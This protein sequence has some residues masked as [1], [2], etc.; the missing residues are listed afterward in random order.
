MTI[1]LYFSNRLEDL[2]EKLSDLMDRENQEKENILEGSLTIVPN[3]N[4]AK[5]L[6]LTLAK[7]RS[8]LMNVDFQYLDTGLWNL[9]GSLDKREEKPVMMDHPFRQMLLLHALQTLESHENAYSPLRQY[10]LGPDGRPG[11]DYGIKLWQLTE[12]MVHLFEEYEFHRS[13]MIRN[14]LNGPAP[15]NGM[16][17]CQQK[18]Y[19]RLQELRDRYGQNTG[20]RILSLE[21][22]AGEMLP[23]SPVPAIDPSIK[24]HRRKYVHIFGL[25]QVSAFHLNLMGRLQR[26][27]TIFMY[28][29]N[30]SREFW[31][32]IKT[33][34]ERRWIRRK[35]A[36]ELTIT[37]LEKELGELLEP[38]DNELLALWGKAGRENIRLLCELTGYDFHACFTR[39][40]TADSVL[41]KL[42]QNILTL[43]TEREVQGKP[44]QDRSLQ[45]F[46]C[47][48]IYREVETAYNSIL[49]NLEKDPTL[50]LTDIAIL[51][52]DISRYK[53][54]IDSF[55]NSGA[56]ILSYNLVDSRAD[57]DS[58]YA[59]GILLLLELAS[60]RFSRKEVFDLIVNPCFMQKWRIHE[61]ELE[62]WAT[63]VNDLNIFHSFDAKEKKK[64]GYP[65]NHYHTWKQG[66]ERLRLSRILSDPEED[67]G[68]S[69]RDFHGLVPF[70]D[71]R[72]GDMDLLEKFSLIIEKLHHAATELTGLVGSA[73]KW[74]AV[75][76]RLCEELLE[77][78][79]DFRGEA[80]V[81]QA[82]TK[83]FLDLKVHDRLAEKTG[84][85]NQP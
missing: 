71:A 24:I 43:S 50:Q 84:R 42:Q 9:I 74:N 16:E 48:G 65:K 33:P 39:E 68:D 26:E 3:Q 69:S 61:S 1:A 5:W 18:L 64:R 66:L 17:H 44:L 53:P 54:V 82:L 41:Q 83:A 55:F 4:L 60:G 77:V 56:G 32:D 58:V 78:P 2:A 49:Y 62:I 14:W 70:T 37:P 22:Y 57:T 6:Q 51:V 75:F 45:I 79:P 40:R 12:R 35:K 13:D 81:Q 25:S 59:K 30:P 85:E 23:S 21:E 76:L 46:A 34:W 8:V 27:Y 15:R 52:S 10:L 47:P 7:Q 38:E 73:E 36:K 67:G 19:L 11:P 72:T 63:W 28:V 80:A 29:L 31:E 20:L